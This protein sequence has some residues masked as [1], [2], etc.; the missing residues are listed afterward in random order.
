MPLSYPLFCRVSTLEAEMILANGFV[1]DTT[2]TLGDGSQLTGVR[3][4][5]EP[6][7]PNDD[8]DGGVLLYLAIPGRRLRDYELIT[9]SGSLDE[10]VVPA[11]VV[12]KYGRPEVVPEPS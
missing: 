10:W 1:D 12:N 5:D 9:A 8:P 11:T 7:A 2:V 4:S 6:V 3:F